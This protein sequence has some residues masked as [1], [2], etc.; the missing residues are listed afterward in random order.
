MHDAQFGLAD[1]KLFRTQACRDSSQL[2][3]CMQFYRPIKHRLD[4]YSRREGITWA[5]DPT[6]TAIP[7]N[8][9]NAILNAKATAWH[10]LIKA[11]IDPK[12]HA[13]TFL[14]EHALLLFVLMT[15]GM[16]NLPRIMRDIMVKRPSG[17][18]RNLL[19]YPMFIAR[20][21]DQYQVQ[22]YA[23]DEIVKIRKVD[24]YCPMVIGMVN[25]PRFVVAESYHLLRHHQLHHRSSIHLPLTHNR[26]PL[27]FLPLSFS[28]HPNLH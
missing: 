10:E 9:D 27:T 11:N 12:T 2:M 18:T 23:R 4:E 3:S 20:L 13:T 14:M 17:N 5:N 8:L 26:Q 16:V 24:M 6:V 22:G 19:S 15:Q 28:T 7:R 25:S 1:G 21:A